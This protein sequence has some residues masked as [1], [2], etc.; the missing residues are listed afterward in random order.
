MAFRWAPDSAC[1]PRSGPLLLAAAMGVIARLRSFAVHLFRGGE[2]LIAMESK[3]EEV[4]HEEQWSALPPEE[5]A[6]WEP[7]DVDGSLSEE[8]MVRGVLVSRPLGRS[9]IDPASA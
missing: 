5:R 6:K 9:A 2:S 7:A 1:P 8:A 3:G 4:I